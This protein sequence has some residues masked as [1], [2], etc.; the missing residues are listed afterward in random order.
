MLKPLKK[1]YR[2]VALLALLHLIGLLGVVGFLVGTDRITAEHVRAAVEVL[3]EGKG[4]AESEA[5]VEA[6]DEEAMEAVP[7]TPA[8]GAAREEI[9]RRNIERLKTQA[10]QQLLLA[11]RAMVDLTRRREEFER[12]QN[13][14][15]RQREQAETERRKEG[16]KKDVEWLSTE[17]PKT[18]LDHLLL[19]ATEDAA[20]LL[21]EMD[22]RRGAKIIATAQ[23]DPRKWAQFLPILKKVR[24]LTPAEEDSG[25]QAAAGET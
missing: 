11:R 1:A 18:A 17:K 9:A 5:E 25:G 21:L 15:S 4:G 8:A 14:L 6:G 2:V 7:E 20:R 12:Q 13:E 10:D 23:K 3:R 24:E 16:F 19:R 22:T